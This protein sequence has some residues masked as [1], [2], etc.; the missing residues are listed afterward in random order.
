M[1][2]KDI[3]EIFLNDLRTGYA[4]KTQQFDCTRWLRTS[5]ETVP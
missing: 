1:L 3:I 4:Q 2:L 5:T